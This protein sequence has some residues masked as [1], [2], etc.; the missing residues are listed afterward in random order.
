MVKIGFK[1][2]CGS[3]CFVNFDEQKIIEDNNLGG[4]FDQTVFD[5][6]KEIPQRKSENKL[7]NYGNGGW[8]ASGTEFG[9]TTAGA[10]ILFDPDKN[11]TQSGPHWTVQGVVN[12]SGGSSYAIPVGS[13]HRMYTKNLEVIFYNPDET[14][15]GTKFLTA[16]NRD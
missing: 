13:A 14:I 16:P 6:L 9:Q 3:I 5:S 1:S 10:K 4:S 2:D 11:N 12:V 7:Y 15:S 8:Y